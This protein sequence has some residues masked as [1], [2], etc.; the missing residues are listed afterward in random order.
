MPSFLLFLPRIVGFFDNYFISL[1][2]K[3]YKNDKV[4]SLNFSGGGILGFNTLII[5]ILQARKDILTKLSK[6]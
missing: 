6:T 4:L 1:Y 2:N 3:R 5:S